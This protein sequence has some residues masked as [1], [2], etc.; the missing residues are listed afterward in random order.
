[1]AKEARRPEVFIPWQPEFVQ[2]EQEWIEWYRANG[3][4]YNTVEGA[5]YAFKALLIEIVSSPELSARSEQQ[6]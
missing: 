3:S 6:H 5:W 1:M 4:E 2:I